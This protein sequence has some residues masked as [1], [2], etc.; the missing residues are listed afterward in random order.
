MR[1]HQKIQITNLL[2]LILGFIIL[3]SCE[4]DHGLEPIRSGI[5]GTIK[6]IGKWPPPDYW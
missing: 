3:L 5:S 2:L 1:T 6:Y 4:T